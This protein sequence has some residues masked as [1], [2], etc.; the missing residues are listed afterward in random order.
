[1][2]V[3]DVTERPVLG[4]G[5]GPYDRTGYPTG[6]DSAVSVGTVVSSATM[7]PS[8]VSSTNVFGTAAST[9]SLT[10]SGIDAGPSTVGTPSAVFVLAPTGI[11]GTG[12][13]GSPQ[14]DK[15]IWFVGVQGS[16]TVGEPTAFTSMG[17]EGFTSTGA[18]GGPRVA[19]NMNPVAVTGVNEFGDAD[20]IATVFIVPGAVDPTDDFGVPSVSRK[21]W[22]FRG[23]TIVLGWRFQKRYEG[24]S[25]LKESGSWSEVSH[26]D[27]GRTLAADIYLPGGHDHIVDDTLK[28]DLVSAGYTVEET[29]L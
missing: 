21:G 13:A 20:T 9:A 22:L 19:Y 4:L 28:A 1:M 7:L 14:A 6:I 3:I 25:L 26:P 29:V 8:S 24:V 23:P 12:S 2:A 16:S 27:L 18:V 17:P 15:S 5:F 11:T 10:V